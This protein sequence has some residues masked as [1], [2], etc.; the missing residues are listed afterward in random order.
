MLLLASLPV[1]AESIRSLRELLDAALAAPDASR[2]ATATA[3]ITKACAVPSLKT[4]D[5][6]LRSHGLGLI[7]A[8]HGNLPRAEAHFRA[9]L[10]DWDALGDAGT[11]PAVRTRL[12]LGEVLARGGRNAEALDVLTRGL[13]EAQSLAAAD[14]VLYP[15]A[16]I[17][18]GLLHSDMEQP[19]RARPLLLEAIAALEDSAAPDQPEL[20]FALHS[21]A[22][23]ELRARALAAAEEYAR[24]AAAMAADA[25]GDEH[26]ETA[27]IRSTLGLILLHER[28]YA[29]A[30]VVLRRAA[31]VIEKR[32]GPDNPQLGNA[33]LQLSAAQYGSGSNAAAE[34]SARR[35]LAI[36]KGDD[37]TAAS[38]P[39]ALAEVNLAGILLAEKKIAEAR[40]VLPGAV[41]TERRLLAQAGGGSRS[42][43]ADGVRRLAEL[44]AAELNW[45]Q[46][47]ARYREAL[48][49]YEA[50]LG[51]SD[52]GIAPVLRAWAG[53]L[54]HQHAPGAEVRSV[55]ARAK[56]LAGPGRG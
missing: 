10:A 22:A 1:H 43:L 17:R 9:A 19:D 20:A 28:Q 48:G 11:V 52:P 32:L 31:W 26:P 50:A 42:M 56:A 39:G 51:P 15:H 27:A 14:A 25:L 41:E 55:E 37:G 33:L 29:R 38:L 8:Q 3:A 6:A 24:R 49:L 45:N 21:L 36:L 40:M 46:A 13:T 30:E 7:D 18:L 5:R 16:L 2:A 35:A 4:S 44:A 34:Q 47:E 23:V 53:A 54:R 12:S